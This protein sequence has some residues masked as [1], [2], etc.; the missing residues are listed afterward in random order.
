VDRYQ[1]ISD[2]IERLLRFMGSC[3]YQAGSSGRARA[4]RLDGDPSAFSEVFPEYRDRP[5]HD[6]YERVPWDSEAIASWFA[7]RAQQAG[8]AP[9]SEWVFQSFR[10]G[11]FGR[12]R[13]EVIRAPSWLLQQGAASFEPESQHHPG[14]WRNAYVLTDGRLALSTRSFS[15]LCES[16]QERLERLTSGVALR[17]VG[18]YHMA[19]LLGLF[20]T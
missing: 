17:A 1:E 4:D 13:A 3:E 9:D 14:G 8:V 20:S 5:W 6:F 12:T 18:L 10:R 19:R 7:Q 11:W 16:D 15:V 2:P